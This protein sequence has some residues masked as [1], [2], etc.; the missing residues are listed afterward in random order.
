ML[1]IWS[2]V[3]KVSRDWW[4]QFISWKS[5]AHLFIQ[6]GAFFAHLWHWPA[7]K[8]PL[9]LSKPTFL[10]FQY[11]CH[12]SVQTRSSHN[13]VVVTLRHL[14][15]TF[16]LSTFPTASAEAASPQDSR[17]LT[18]QPSMWQSWK[19]SLMTTVATRFLSLTL[20]PVSAPLPRPLHLLPKDRAP[21]WLPFLHLDFLITTLQEP[22]VPA[23]RSLIALS[24]PS[25][26][27][28]VPSQP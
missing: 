23:R 14:L 27:L 7:H 26:V 13:L 15:G 20:C 12:T 22:R 2:K 18:P 28:P 9:F 1:T 19:W 3:L 25:L 8:E 17:E 16:S 21:F 5:N 10:Y 11:L 24:L 4:R 6:P